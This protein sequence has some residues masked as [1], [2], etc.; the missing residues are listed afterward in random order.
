MTWVQE[1]IGVLRWDTE[2]RRVNIVLEVLLLSQNQANPR[3]GHLEQVL[4]IFAFHKAHPKHTLYPASPELPNLDYGDFRTYKED[5]AEIYRDAEE[6]LSHRM[7]MP[8][9]RSLL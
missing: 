4:H 9:G 2:I 7:P 1:L 3:E 8:G 5:F 6:F